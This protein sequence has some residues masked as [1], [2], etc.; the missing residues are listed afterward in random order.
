MD[1]TVLRFQGFCCPSPGQTRPV[2]PVGEPH[3]TSFPPNYGCDECPLEYYCHRDAFY[4]EKSI[5]AQCSPSRNSTD[6]FSVNSPLECVKGVC[7]C[8]A[9]FSHIDGECKRVMC[10]VGLRGEPSVDRNNQLIRCGRSSDCSQGQMCDPNTRGAQKTMSKR[11]KP[12]KMAAVSDP[13]T[14]AID[15]NPGRSKSAAP[16]MDREDL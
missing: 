14:S 6:E 13:V 2:C 4:P 9:G 12:V 5:S 16:S 10:T 7:T 8:R 11:A 3:E 15:R 1:R